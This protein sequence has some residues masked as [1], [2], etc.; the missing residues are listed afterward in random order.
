MNLKPFDNIYFV[1]VGGIGMSALA[2]Y[3]HKKNIKVSGYDKTQTKITDSLISMG[4][5][6]V[7]S[8]DYFS[9]DKE[10][11]N[12]ENTLVIITPAIPKSNSILNFFK[13]RDF[14]I[15][16]RAEVLGLITNNTKCLAIAGTHGKTTTTSILAHLMLESN[17]KLTAFLGGI[18]ENYKSNFIQNGS[19]FTIVEADEFDRSFLEL[20]PDLACITSI[21]ADHLDIYSNKTKLTNAF[22]EFSDLLPT[23]KKLFVHDSVN[24]PGISYGVGTS[25]DYSAQNLS[26]HNGTYVFDLKTPKTI[27]KGLKFPIPGRHNLSNAV[28]AFAMALESG[29]NDVNLR[30]ALESYR[31]VERRFSYKI[32][33]NDFVFIDDYAHHPKEIDA[34]RNTI[35]EIYPD[36][37]TTAVFQPHLF[38]RTK[39]LADEFAVSL[40]QFDTVLLL[41]IYPARELPIKGVSSKWLLDKINVKKKKL[42]TKD[43]LVKAILKIDNPVLVTMG[44][45]D[46]DIEV[47]SI[48]KTL[49]NA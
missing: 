30:S 43:K 37:K 48:T 19:N 46:I 3:F 21:D 9:I 8:D 28:V 16:K 27:F 24:L 10:H 47:N 35:N 36:K 41:D 40:S 42:V 44:A 6:I 5:K 38:S 49:Q 25:T 45:G 15:I 22:K 39:D 14:K 4:I 23:K 2:N 31:G 18:S 34:V 11:M 1:G 26:I 29:C 7:F 32:K 17:Q 20:K 13:S 12:P 33:T